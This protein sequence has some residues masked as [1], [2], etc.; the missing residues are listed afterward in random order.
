MTPE[1]LIER[2]K[3]RVEGRYGLNLVPGKPEERSKPGDERAVSFAYSGGEVRVRPMVGRV[4]QDA[5]VTDFRVEGGWAPKLDALLDPF[6]QRV[7]ESPLTDNMVSVG[8]SE[9]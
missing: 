7:P 8:E 2:M 3:D 9:A 4:W 1:L 5:L 6:F